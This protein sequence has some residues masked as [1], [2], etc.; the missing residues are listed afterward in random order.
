MEIYCPNEL[1]IATNGITLSS[2]KKK[3]QQRQQS[4]STITVDDDADYSEFNDDHRQRRSNNNNNANERDDEID[5]VDGDV[6]PLAK[7]DSSLLS[8]KRKS[9]VDNDATMSLSKRRSISDVTMRLDFESIDTASSTAE[10]STTAPTTTS[11]TTTISNSNIDS[12]VVKPADNGVETPTNNV[13]LQPVDDENKIDAQRTVAVNN[14]DHDEHDN[15]DNDDSDNDNYTSNVDDTGNSNSDDEHSEYSQEQRR[16]RRKSINNNNTTTNNVDDA[17]K[18]IDPQRQQINDVSASSLELLLRNS[19]F[20]YETTTVVRQLPR[21]FFSGVMR[22]SVLGMALHWNSIM[23]GAT[24]SENDQTMCRRNQR[25]H[26]RS[27][28]MLK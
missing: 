7:S 28:T 9:S 11:T 1:E 17:T 19:A 2:S 10:I 23:L 15:A 16:L 20:K 26:T 3:Q 25:L 18:P 24:G 8:K 5:R 21:V 4:K 14:H 12:I 13:K 6:R 22:Q 27:S